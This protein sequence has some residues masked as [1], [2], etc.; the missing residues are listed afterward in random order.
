MEI[1]FIYPKFLLL[2]FLIPLFILIYFFSF[3]YNRKKAMVF[4]NFSAMKR[5]YEI[6]F[7]SRNFVA[8]YLMLI[9][10]MLIILSLAGIGVTMHAKT[11]SFSYIIAIDASQSMTANDVSPNRFMVAK[12]E[13]KNFIDLFPPGVEIGI[14][15]FS[16]DATIYQELDS[17]KIKSKLALD[18]IQIG[19]ISGTNIYNALLTANDMFGSRQMKSVIL[20]SDGQLNIREAPQVI[21]LVNR[22]N[23]IVN[24][25]A[26]GTEEG[27]VMEEFNVVSKV[28]EDLLKSLA[29]NSGGQFFNARDHDTMRDS[30]EKIFLETNRDVTIYLQIYLLIAAACVLTIFWILYNLRFK[31]LP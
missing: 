27:G 14:I 10:L 28:D 2:L 31:T 18:A 1:V 7:F 15:G 21:R 3:S 4:S 8:L 9:T 30:L 16:G 19:E 24:T 11:S 13:A 20:I 17:A 29:F 25:I 5:F 26:I 6:E 22:N 23:L 12:S